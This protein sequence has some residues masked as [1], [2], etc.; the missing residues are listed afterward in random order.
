MSKD[1]TWIPTLVLHGVTSYDFTMILIGFYYDYSRKLGLPRRSQEVPGGPRMKTRMKNEDEKLGCKTSD[2]SRGP[3]TL[4]KG[5]D[6]LEERLC[7]P[8]L[9]DLKKD[10]PN[11]QHLEPS[12]GVAGSAV[13]DL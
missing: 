8:A 6:G 9:I 3:L 10:L 12:T 1:Q 7:D 4:G 2:S 11:R 13:T 5:V